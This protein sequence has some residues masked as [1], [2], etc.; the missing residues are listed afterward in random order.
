MYV[1]HDHVLAQRRLVGEVI[2]AGAERLH[3]F[4]PGGGFEHL[5]RQHGREGH[6]G[7]GVGDIGAD[8]GMVIDQRH[9]HVGKARL[10]AVAYSGADFRGQAEQNKQ[11]GHRDGYLCR[12]L[13]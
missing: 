7:V 1:G 13:A 3:P 11:V 2:G 6:H 5:R 4:E 9:R 12:A 10:Q 8:L